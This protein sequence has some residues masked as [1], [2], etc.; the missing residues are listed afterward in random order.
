MHLFQL[1]NSTA[2]YYRRS[3]DMVGASFVDL[4]LA[5]GIRDLLGFRF[6]ELFKSIAIAG[7][8]SRSSLIFGFDIAATESAFPSF[9]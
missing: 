3:A 7:L 6:V 2:R 8:F 5:Q 4:E 9:K 1:R